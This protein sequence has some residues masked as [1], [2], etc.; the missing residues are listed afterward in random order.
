MKKTLLFIIVLL[1][2]NTH[3]QNIKFELNIKTDSLENNDNLYITGDLEVLGN[4]NPAGLKFNKISNN[5]FSLSVYLPKDSII[6]YKITR[7]KWENESLNG[8]KKI[9]DNFKIKAHSDTS[10]T[11]EIKYW[12]DKHFVKQL[13]VITGKTV[14]YKDFV[15]PGLQNRD[16]IVLLPKSYESKKDKKYPVMYV[17]DGQNAFDPST[18]NFGIDWQIDEV[19]DSLQRVGDIEEIIV[20]ASYCT[21]ERFKEYSYDSLGKIY[22][23]DLVNN[24]KPFIDNNFRTLKD[25]NNTAVMGSSMGGLISFILLWEYNDVFSKAACLSPAFKID[26]LDYVTFVKNDTKTKLPFK[27]YIDNGG[28]GLEERLQPGI[29]DILDVLKEKGYAENKDFYWVKDKFAEHN[30]AAWSKRIYK[31]IKIFFSK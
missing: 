21:S 5:L 13:S 30:E 27:L 7:G 2:L 11:L 12:K 10:V 16:V 17:H 14:L 1:G 25:R 6:N 8:F 22:C 20:V 15:F 3:S 31:P 24:L 28:I 18:A 19:I 23:Y 29:D 26:V 9:P 4:W